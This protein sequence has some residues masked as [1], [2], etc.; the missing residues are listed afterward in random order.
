MIGRGGM[1]L[2]K[3]VG[4]QE[5]IGDVFSESEEWLVKWTRPVSLKIMHNDRVFEIKYRQLSKC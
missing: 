4:N 5:G 1:K 3:F 2:P